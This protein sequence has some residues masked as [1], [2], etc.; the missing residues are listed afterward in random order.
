MLS[1]D[2][3]KQ[4]SPHL[5]WD[6]ESV[7]WDQHPG[8]I[9]QRILE[10]GMLSDFLLLKSRVGIQTIA[11]HAKRLRTLDRKALHLIAMLSNSDLSEFRCFTTT[12]L[13]QDSVDF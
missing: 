6:V 8:F 4:L 13:A 2:D 9:V 5:F 12:P 3:L 1:Q 7:D 11:D 10:Y